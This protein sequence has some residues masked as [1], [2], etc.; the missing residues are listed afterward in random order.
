M[1]YNFIYHD[2]FSTQFIEFKIQIYIINTKPK[3]KKSVSQFFYM[4]IIVKSNKFSLLISSILYIINL[5]E[6]LK[7]WHDN[8]IRDLSEFHFFRSYILA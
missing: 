1:Y 5:R 8:K 2:K 6:P 4:E 7:L 3:V